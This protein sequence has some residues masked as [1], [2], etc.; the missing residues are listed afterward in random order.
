MDF[1]E[2]MEAENLEEEPVNVKVESEA[3]PTLKV[4]PKTEPKEEMLM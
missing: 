4:E 2:P 3:T 1:D